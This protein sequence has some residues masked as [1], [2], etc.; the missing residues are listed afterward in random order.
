MALILD[1]GLAVCSPS[2]SF[3]PQPGGEYGPTQ[4]CVKLKPQLWRS[5]A[6]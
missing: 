1:S 5:D 4:A 2:V 3:M 6:P